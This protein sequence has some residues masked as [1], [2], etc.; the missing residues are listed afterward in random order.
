MQM[1]FKVTNTDWLKMSSKGQIY[2]IY[3]DMYRK[4]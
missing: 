2:G 4:Q 1:V 3:A